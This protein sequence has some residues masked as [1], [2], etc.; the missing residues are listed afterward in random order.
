[1]FENR[2][3]YKQH[4]RERERDVLKKETF[5]VTI[6]K[7]NVSM[8][9]TVLNIKTNTASYTTTSNVVAAAQRYIENTREQGMS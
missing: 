2:E 7:R 9:D 1:M 4:R 3:V 8:F 6:P 5:V